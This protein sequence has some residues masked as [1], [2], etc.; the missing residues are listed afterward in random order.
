MASVIRGSDNFDS[1][2]IVDGAAKVWVNFNGLGTVVIRESYNVSSITDNG[3]GDYTVSFDTAM[4]DVNYCMTFGGCRDASPTGTANTH[5][6][7]V[8]GTEDGVS[9]AHVFG[10]QSNT[11]V[12]L[13]VIQVA[14]F[15]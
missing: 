11:A 5:N 9:Q 4:P 12:D 10:Y 15:R 6:Y 14:I 2:G 3:I 13:E 7:D 8:S 1:A